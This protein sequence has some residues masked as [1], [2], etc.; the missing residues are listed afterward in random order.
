MSESGSRGVRVYRVL[1]HLLPR[2]FRRDRG[3]AMERLFLDMVRERT[4]EGRSPGIGFWGR[5]VWDTIDQAVRE[6][7]RPGRAADTPRSSRGETM[8]GSVAADVRS[9]AR[10]MARQPMYAM[11]TV[12]MMTLAIAGNAAV[13]RIFNGLFLRP[14][15]F[16]D[17]EELVDLDETAPQWNLTY[18]GIAYPDLVAWREGN[19]GLEGLGAYSAGS[20]DL[21]RAGERAVHVELVRATYDLPAVLRLEPVL[22]RFFTAEEDIPGG[23][24]VALLSWG[25]WQDQE[26]GRSDVPGTTIRLSGRS[27]EVIGVMP[28]AAAFVTDA[29]VWVPLQDDVAA[30]TGWY[31]TGIGRLSPGVTPAAAREDLLR[32]HRNLVE[33]RSFNAITSPVVSRM[34][35]RY[36]GSLRAG[37]SVLL[38]S[39]AIVL[40]IACANIAGLMLA[41]SLV[42]GR[43]MGIRVAMGATTGRI[44]RQLLTESLVLSAAGALLG[45]LLGLWVSSIL[46]GHLRQQFPP[47]VTFDLDW[48]FLLFT[49]GATVGAAF[50]FGL[51]PALQSARVEA[52]QLLQGTS[53]RASTTGSRRRT[54][55]VLVVAEVALALVLLIAAGLGV[56]DFRRLLRVDPG[57]RTGNLLTYSLS[58]EGERY[59]GNDRRLAFWSDHLERLRALPGVVSAAAAS[60][61]PLGGHWGWLFTVE[62]A[63]PRAPDEPNPIVLNRVVST[64]YFETM[65]VERIAGRDFDDR[66]GRDEGSHVVIV[67]ETF[68]RHFFPEGG[69]VLGRRIKAAGDSMWMTIVGIA[70]DVRHYGVDQELQPGVYQPVRQFMSRRMQVA[71][72]TAGPPMTALESVRAALREQ[73]P[74]LAPFE[75]G[76]MAQRYDDALWTRR[77]AAWLIAVFSSIALVLAVAG[78][79]G[80]ISYGVTQRIPEISIRMALGAGRGRVLWRI[81]GEGVFLVGSGMGLGLIAAM[82]AARLVSGVLVGTSVTDPLTWI[83]VTALL[84]AVGVLANLLPARRAASLQPMRALKGD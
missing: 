51:A 52:S 34:R 3:A 43:E 83:G 17:P 60:T 66:D 10:S 38:G 72:R 70:R 59:D 80:V 65:G 61:L 16:E 63:P 13:F 47:W 64:G 19:R 4:R 71:V 9:A 37:S 79:Y 1:L 55:R 77:A 62:G 69:D 6:R 20:A 48:R 76:T 46:V 11:L 54:M 5:V 26:G 68:R 42:R 41:R 67:D 30:F 74:E 32:V 50:L 58:P 57:F 84:F 56:H 33:K 28:P 23:P 27:Y 39:V 15:P 14:L 22:G 73:D 7:V 25:F 78:L 31:L 81:M 82:L 75:I 8:I 12:L 2:R 49:A 24:G 29:S 40:L 18:T 35:D 36:L 21:V 45:G 53:T 44:V